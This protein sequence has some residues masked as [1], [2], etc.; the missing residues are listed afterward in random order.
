MEKLIKKL[1]GHSGSTV[2]LMQ[3]DDNMFV[4]KI[5]N[6]QRNYE[7]LSALVGYVDVPKIYHYDGTILDMEYIHGTDMKNYLL[8][9]STKE[10]SDFLINTLT[11]FSSKSVDKDYTNVY[12]EMLSWLEDGMF[13]FTK[14]ELIDRLPKVL[15]KSVYHG[16]MTLENII[17]STSGR[18]YF[19]DAVTLKYDS[20]VFDIAKLR[21]D[22]E[23]KWFLRRDPVALDGK[24]LKLQDNIL[25][26]YPIANDDCLLIL[27]L[28]RVYLHCEKDSLEYNFIVKEINRLWK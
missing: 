22:L 2:A 1:K 25:K 6:V 20:W 19:I 15:P 14:E 23:C 12:N 5:E 18:F 13:P 7:R 11:M 28:L 4:R 21:Q 8:N 27:M 17:H 3:A 26:K 10:L 16:D 24:L 9:N